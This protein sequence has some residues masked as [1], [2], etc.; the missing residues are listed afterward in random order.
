MPGVSRAEGDAARAQAREAHAKRA[1]K[2]AG[3][4][5]KV[6]REMSEQAAAARSRALEE[7]KANG[8]S[9]ADRRD[10]ML[11]S[12]LKILQRELPP[13]APPKMRSAVR[14][15]STGAPAAGAPAAAEPEPVLS[16]VEQ[17]SLQILN[18]KGQKDKEMEDEL[19][20]LA[21]RRAARKHAAQLSRDRA[22]S[23]LTGLA[24]QLP[25]ERAAAHRSLFSWAPPPLPAPPEH[26]HREGDECELLR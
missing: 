18:D 21:A 23:G 22:A 11:G 16:A 4:R 9:A 13:D 8:G 17:L 6:K 15:P 14:I 19:E 26:E 10:E 5:E 2:E 12:A 24:A 7:L 20:Q 1:A 25:D 3:I